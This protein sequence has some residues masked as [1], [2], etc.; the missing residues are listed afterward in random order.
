MEIIKRDMA[1]GPS[2]CE[3]HTHRLQRDDGKP[4]IVALAANPVHPLRIE[5]RADYNIVP[6]IVRRWTAHWCT[7]KSS[8]ARTDGSKPRRDGK[9]A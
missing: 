3:R 4:D 5:T 2:A 8:N 1:K 6:L 7:R 9:T